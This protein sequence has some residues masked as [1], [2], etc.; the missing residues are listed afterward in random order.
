M[1]TL[2]D[3]ECSQYDN[4][5]SICENCSGPFIDKEELRQE[6]IK[7]AKRLQEEIGKYEIEDKKQ[8]EKFKVPPE[9]QFEM[10]V[11]TPNIA[12]ALNIAL[13]MGK[14]ELIKEFFNITE[15]ELNA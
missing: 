7:E 15:E 11:L 13:K 3:F 1:K 8:N 14:I 4:C 9:I 12:E 2:K 5:E 10:M 6:A